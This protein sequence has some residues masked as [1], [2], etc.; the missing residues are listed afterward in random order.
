MTRKI[1]DK[2]YRDLRKT[3]ELPECTK[4]YIA[5]YWRAGTK[6]YHWFTCLDKDLNEI[7]QIRSDYTPKA[8]R[9]IRTENAN[10]TAMLA[11]DLKPL[12]ENYLLVTRRSDTGAVLEAIANTVARDAGWRLNEK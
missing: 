8:T 9:I 5:E 2:E 4:Y 11:Y 3:N 6:H 10:D 1:T 7:D 12:N